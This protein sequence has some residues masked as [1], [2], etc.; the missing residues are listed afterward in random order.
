MVDFAPPLDRRQIINALF[1]LLVSGC[2]TSFTADSNVGDPLLR[3]VSSFINL[4][5]GAPVVGPGIA[6][7]SEILAIDSDAGT[8]L[9]DTPVLTGGAGLALFAGFQTVGRRLKPWSQVSALPALFLRH[10][11]GDYVERSATSAT[12]FITPGGLPPHVYIDVEIWLYSLAGLDGI[13]EDAVD[14][15]I[16]IVEAV[17]RPRPYGTAQTLGGLVRDCWIA[18]KYTVEPGDLDGQAKAVIPV[19]LFVPGVSPPGTAIP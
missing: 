17:L 2:N 18:G 7:G 12:S 15:L 3:N 13:P 5:R 9:L 14:A 10:I 1:D 8:V 4:R 19:R 11:G 16:D 6:A